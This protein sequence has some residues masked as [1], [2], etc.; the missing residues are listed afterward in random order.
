[1][2]TVLEYLQKSTEFLQKKGIASPRLNAELLLADVL[3]CK[4]LELYLMYERPLA[5]KEIEIYREYLVRRGKYEP[6]PYITGTTEFYGHR[7][8]VTPSV[9][10]PRQ[11]TEIL[12]DAAKLLMKDVQNP[13]ILDLCSGSGNIG[14]TLAKEFPGATV[15]LL[16]IDRDAMKVAYN[17]AKS[18]ALD[19]GVRFHVQ[20]VR[21]IADDLGT[22]DLISANPPY[23][24]LAE[25]QTLQEEIVRYE[26]R[27]AVT[28]ES[29]GYSLYNI[30][31]QNAKR[32][33]KPHGVLVFEVGHGMSSTVMEMMK[34][35]G[36]DEV[37]AV[38]DY[39]DIE[40]VVYGRLY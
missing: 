26:P 31:T 36:F 37:T 3:S 19:N 16:D 10:I 23:V 25:Y 30:I 11:E 13:V 20:D 18:L 34:A 40:R 8:A 24:S 2:S 21:N 4:R 27:K 7:F 9:L 29:D 39:L 5:D 17:N 22:F 1:M 33:L 15:S 32:F 6:L 35:S 28:D 14:L 38:R 12:I